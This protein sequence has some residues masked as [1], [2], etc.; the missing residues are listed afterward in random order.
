[1]KILVATDHESGP[2]LLKIL[3]ARSW[4]ANDEFR[5][6]TVLNTSSRDYAKAENSETPFIKIKELGER[7]VATTDS[8]AQALSAAFP[9]CKITTAVLD[10]H[11]ADA[12]AREANRWQSNLIVIGS[13]HKRGMTRWLEGSVS[14]G[15]VKSTDC[16]ILLVPVTADARAGA[17]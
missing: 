13:H 12:I 5:I 9:T 2:A 17:K 8:V 4:S 7:Y 10:G 14:E 11:I 15:V 6:V 1:M 3:T 16:S